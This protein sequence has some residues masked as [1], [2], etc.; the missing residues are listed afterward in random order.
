MKIEPVIG[1]NYIKMV[2][3]YI[4]D[5]KQILFLKIVLVLYPTFYTEFINRILTNGTYVDD[6]TLNYISSE[7]KYMLGLSPLELERWNDC[8]LELTTNGKTV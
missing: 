3:R 6:I 2:K 1:N 4:L 5:S 8:K 7:I